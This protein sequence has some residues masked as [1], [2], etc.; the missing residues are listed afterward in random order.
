[1]LRYTQGRW[2]REGHTCQKPL[3]LDWVVHHHL[4]VHSAFSGEEAVAGEE[5]ARMGR[6]SVRSGGSNA[7]L[8]I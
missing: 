4:A 3:I 5:A 6:C 8:E 1:V 2:R 7:V